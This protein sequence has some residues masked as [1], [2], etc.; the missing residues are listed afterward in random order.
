[1]QQEGATIYKK[2]ENA[3]GFYG[4]SKF[5]ETCFVGWCYNG[6]FFVSQGTAARLKRGVSYYEEPEAPEEEDGE[7]GNEEEEVQEVD[8]RQG[9]EGEGERNKDGCSSDTIEAQLINFKTK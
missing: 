3:P 7:G 6:I 9:G 2:K 5:I 4:S 8:D 1:M